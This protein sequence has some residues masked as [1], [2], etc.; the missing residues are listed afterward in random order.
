VTVRPG[1]KDFLWVAGGTILL[2]VIFLLVLHNYREEDVAEKAAFKTK[3]VELV[4]RMRAGLS[5]ASEAEK[6]AVMATTD[7]ESQTFAEQARAAS[8]VVE[9]RRDELAKLL[10]TGGTHNERDLLSQFSRDLT[11][12]QHIDRELLDL[13]V[14]NTNLKAWALAFGP[15]A[16]ALAGVDDALSSILKESATSTA[17]EAKQ[18]MLLAARAQSG[19]WRLQALLPPHISEESDQKMNEL[20]ARV[21]KEDQKVRS[22]LD[23][24]AAILGSRSPD[25]EAAMSGYAR[26]SGLKTRILELSRQNTNVRSLIMS[27]NQKRIAVRICQE[28]LDALE[29]AIQQEP[30]TDRPPVMP[31]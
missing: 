26:F 22:D 24:L 29:Q 8:V 3:R 6:S 9:Q 7:Q 27:L 16:D 13:A 20:E 17:A 12:C 25:L 11:E 30:L 14:K 19:A 2:I 28:G 21:A 18:V 15:A 5:S 31:R 4:A 23:D 10:E 1:L